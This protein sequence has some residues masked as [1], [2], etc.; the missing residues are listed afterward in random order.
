[1]GSDKETLEE[2]GVLDA[3]CIKHCKSLLDGRPPPSAFRVCPS[4]SALPAAGGPLGLYL[5]GAAQGRG[6]GSCSSSTTSA[7]GRSSYSHR[8]PR[9]W[10][11][12]ISSRPGYGEPSS[13]SSP[14]SPNP[15]LDLPSPLNDPRPPHSFPHSSRLYASPAL[16][17][18]SSLQYAYSTTPGSLPSL[19]PAAQL[20]IH[21]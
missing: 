18:S 6:P 16:V 4:E 10:S 3:S 14:S 8:R 15:Y 7:V 21:D 5:L 9:T 19:R 17:P 1:M 13:S 11:F 20:P 2:G 12:W